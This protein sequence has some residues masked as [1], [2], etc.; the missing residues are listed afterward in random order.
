MSFHR[1]ILSLLKTDFSKMSKLFYNS[2]IN[3]VSFIKKSWWLWHPHGSSQLPIT[4]VPG[5][6][7]PTSD[8]HRHQTCT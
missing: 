2:K 6:A 1:E 3:Y 7:M 4:P 5:H 8:L